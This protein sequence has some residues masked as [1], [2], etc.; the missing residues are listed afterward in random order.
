[1]Q[2]SSEGVLKQ[3]F[4]IH[5]QTQHESEYAADTSER[6][7]GSRGK[8]AAR[9]RMGKTRTSLRHEP[10]HKRKSRKAGE[11]VERAADQ[12]LTPHPSP[13]KTLLEV[14]A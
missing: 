3:N 12:L 8:K 7:R 10:H 13:K 4:R 9:K 11:R 5:A 1:M 6:A 14:T 2:N